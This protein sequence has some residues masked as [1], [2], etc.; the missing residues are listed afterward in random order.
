MILENDTGD[1]SKKKKTVDSERVSNLGG[2]GN[3]NDKRR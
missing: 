2:T 1:R 3:R